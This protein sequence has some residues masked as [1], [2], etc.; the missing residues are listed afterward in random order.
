MK[1]MPFSLEAEQSVLGAI[2]IDERVMQ[3]ALQRLDKTDFYKVSHTHIYDA[4]QT[5][6]TRKIDLDYATI[7]SVL[8]ERNLVEETGGLDY[9]LELAN[10]L[11]TAE[12]V[13]SYIDIV[14]NKSLA[15]QVIQMATNIAEQTYEQ[16]LEI[17]A[18]FDYTEQQL[19]EV[20]KQRK[21]A[22]FRPIGSVVNDVISGIEKHKNKD[23]FL[24]GLPTGYLDLDDRTLGFQEGNLIILAARPSVGKSAFAINLAYNIA[25]KNKHVAFFSLEMSA[26]QIVTRMLSTV[27]SINNQALQSGNINSRQWRQVEHA[28]TL[29]SRL[30]IYFD[31]AS[32][33]N[34]GEVYTKCRQ[35]KQEDKLDFVVIDYL[36][37]LTGTGNYGGNRVVEVSEISRR[38][39]NLA[40]DLGIPV[41][42][43]SQLSRNVEQ[44]TDKRPNMADLR[45]S[46]SIEQDADIV[47]FMYRDDYY[48][49]ETTSQPNI[50]EISISK[51]RS[52][53]TGKFDLL[54]VKDYG[55]FR[56]VGYRGE[57]ND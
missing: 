47:M 11:P 26:E 50:V 10:L 30:N 35:L 4:M 13:D 42:A 16:E 27:S 8:E 37:L 31:D 53:A 7:T 3:R 43:L 45:E 14:K 19:F 56:N 15:R 39:K 54:F 36:Q 28:A 25:E 55:S 40:R 22:E 17:G 38:L 12:N 1:K 9:L 48:N 6:S 44:R 29:L 52:G 20:T 2:L 34:V 18:L 21:S 41:L 5:L 33:S 46:G 23:G 49:P 24:V 32:T 51:N 57:D